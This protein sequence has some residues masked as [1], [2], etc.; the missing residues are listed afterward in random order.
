MEEINHEKVR[1][2][3]KL[4]EAYSRHRDTDFFSS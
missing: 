2:S 3:V 1:M 4:E